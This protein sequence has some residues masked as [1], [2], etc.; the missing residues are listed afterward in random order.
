MRAE[1]RYWEAQD[2]YSDIVRRHQRRAMRIAYHMVCDPA[3]ADEVVQDA[4]VKA[5]QHFC[6]LFSDS[7]ALPNHWFT[8]IPDLFNSF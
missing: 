2:R 7:A 4:F 1:G 5:Y 6:P 8:R 3:D